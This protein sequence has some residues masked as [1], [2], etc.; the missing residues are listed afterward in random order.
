VQAGIGKDMN[1]RN[2]NLNPQNPDPEKDPADVGIQTDPAFDRLLDEALGFDKTPMPKGLNDRVL[3][4][5]ANARRPLI[6]EYDED[7]ETGRV[8]GVIGSVSIVRWSL[9]GLAALLVFGASAM[10]LLQGTGITPNGQTSGQMV[11]GSGNET[12][13]TS[14]VSTALLELDLS[15]FDSLGYTESDALDR[16]IA[17]LSSRIDQASSPRDWQG[18]NNSIDQ[19]N[20]MWSTDPE[21]RGESGSF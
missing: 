2:N 17:A 19:L 3:Q 9:I 20:K 6:D 15:R 4:A 18:L 5:M 10:V 7:A 16:D 21:L 12:D 8:A 11:D 14:P 13:P 1:I